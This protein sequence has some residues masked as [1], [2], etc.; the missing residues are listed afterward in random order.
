MRDYTLNQL[1]LKE[2]LNWSGTICEELLISFENDVYDITKL[3]KDEIK[4]N[5][6]KP[7]FGKNLLLNENK[8]IMEEL[9]EELK[10]NNCKKVGKLSEPKKGL[11]LTREELS[12]YIGNGEI[13]EGRVHPPIYICLRGKIYDVSYGGYHFYN[14]KCQYHLFSGK[15][16]SVAF[17]KMSFHK[18][19][20]NNNDISTLSHAE[21]KCLDNWIK[22]YE[23]Y[24]IVGDLI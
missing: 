9:M 2:I 3:C 12:K 20:I 17:A 19:D 10:N 11:R 18:E 8:E 16:V 23:K 15:D 4:Y 24:P 6:L 13:P 1:S 5:N 21:L 22:S 14:D 7:Y